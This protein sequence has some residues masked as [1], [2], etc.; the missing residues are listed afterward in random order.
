MHS[1]R[2]L[3]EGYCEHPQTKPPRRDSNPHMLYSPERQSGVQPVGLRGDI[4]CVVRRRIP[5]KTPE[6]WCHWMVTIHLLSLIRGVYYLYTTAAY[7]T[8]T[9]RHVDLTS[10]PIPYGIQMGF[11]FAV[12][13]SEGI[14]LLK[15]LKSHLDCGTA[16]T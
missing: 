5:P 7:N 6:G 4:L 3:I 14:L 10:A 12:S 16:R 2:P 15:H 1:H 13:F 11:C 8:V 9:K